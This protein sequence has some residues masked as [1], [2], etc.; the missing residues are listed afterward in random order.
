MRRPSILAPLLLLGAVAAAAQTET[1]IEFEL[2]DQFERVHRDSDFAGR[3]LYVIGSDKDGSR[4]NGPWAKAIS[5]ALGDRDRARLATFGLA[6][7]SGVPFFLRGFVKGKFP[8]ERE[9]WVLLDWKGRFRRAYGFEAGSANVLAFAADGRLAYRF[10]ARQVE[11]AM[12]AGFV[13][14]LR[15][16]LDE[17]G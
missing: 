3:V 1:L 8:Q 9:R 14:K 16:L 12:L 11:P 7:V 10:D 13:A 2:R 6:D 17:S 15:A 5:G 4:F